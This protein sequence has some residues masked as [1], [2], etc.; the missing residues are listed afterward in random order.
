MES[1]YETLM[2]HFKYC[3]FIVSMILVFMV[4]DRWS[5]RDGF[6]TYLNNA[7]TMT[8]LL[9]GVVA[10]FYSYISNDGMSR[11]LGS[12]SLVANE[13]KEVKTDIQRFA[14]QTEN[15]TDVS[16]TN[17]VLVKDAS[18]FLSETMASLNETLAA[19]SLQND[20]LKGL[21]ADLPSKIDQLD[22]KVAKALEEKT[23]PADQRSTFE[24]PQQMITR[25]LARIPLQQH[26]LL[27]A[28][29][30]S[31]EKKLPL[32]LNAVA[33][34]IE[35]DEVKQLQGFLAC[36]HIAELCIRKPLET[37]ERTYEILRINSELKTKTKSSFESY[38][39]GHFVDDVESKTRWMSRKTA[40]E[41]LFESGGNAELQVRRK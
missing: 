40:V 30:M 33:K 13:I 37:K 6:T 23:P 36:M 3:A 18:I 26:L 2:L 10:I 7:A 24:I 8:S 21:V 32:N 41:A 14:E 9:L 20:S 25:F 17:S 1:K 12:I 31:A 29:V 35:W 19:I 16:R 22:G 39:Q 27:L 4:V 5:D 11:S 34:A 38:V 15:A 28:C